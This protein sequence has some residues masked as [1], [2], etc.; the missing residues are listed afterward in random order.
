ML[1]AAADGCVQCVRQYHAKVGFAS[2][3]NPA[4]VWSGSFSDSRFNAW[5]STFENQ[6]ATTL[7]GQESVREYLCHLPHSQ[8]NI[9]ATQINWK[10]N[11][12]LERRNELM[13]EA[14]E[15]PSS[16]QSM[17]NRWQRR[18]KHGQQVSEPVAQANRR[19]LVLK[20]IEE[21]GSVTHSAL[22]CEAQSEPPLCLLCSKISCG[23]CYVIYLGPFLQDVAVP[24]L[25]CLT[26]R[27][28]A[29]TEY[30]KACKTCTEWLISICESHLREIKLLH[31]ECRGVWCDGPTPPDA[32]LQ[33]LHKARVLILAQLKQQC[34][35][36]LQQMPSFWQ[37]HTL[38]MGGF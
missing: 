13:V 12:L 16:S 21:P 37:H 33:R 26:S 15:R 27:I 17:D 1:Y 31:L 19:A 20:R 5:R 34:V 2:E 22:H 14:Q 9:T 18:K 28:M 36:L 29:G 24:G 23:N 11:K 4:S 32:S 30:I 6:C 38:N 25:E 35:D 3:S 10:K 8:E 7:H